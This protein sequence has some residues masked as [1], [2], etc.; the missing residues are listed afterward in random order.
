MATSLG[1]LM[2]DYATGKNVTPL[3]SG[4]TE[5]NWQSKLVD[6]LP[7]EWE[8]KDKWANEKADVRDILSHNT[9]LAGYVSFAVVYPDFVLL[10]IMIGR[11]FS[12]GRMIPRRMWF[13]V[14]D[15]LIRLSNFVGNLLIIMPHV[16][17]SPPFFYDVVT[18][19][20]ICRCT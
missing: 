16:T 17:P 11:T 20:A 6:L 1:I 12:M 14:C 18:D 7:G 10:L 5:F 8:L 9:G 3:P 2:E 13:F 15:I 19:S 4:V